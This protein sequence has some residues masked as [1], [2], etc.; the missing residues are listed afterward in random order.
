MKPFEIFGMIIFFI[1][2]V[3]LMSWFA[4]V[5]TK[6]ID[7]A[8]GARQIIVTIGKDVKSIVEEIKDD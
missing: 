2:L 6:E 8:G 5:L 1:L 4:H 7:Q 3:V